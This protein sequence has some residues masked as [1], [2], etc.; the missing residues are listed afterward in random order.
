MA[1]TKSKALVTKLETY[2]R[3]KEKIKSQRKGRGRN[4]NYFLSSLN[5]G[6]MVVRFLTQAEKVERVADTYGKLVRKASYVRASMQKTA[7]VF[8]LSNPGIEFKVEPIFKQFKNGNRRLKGY[9]I[10]RTA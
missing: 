7:K 2:K 4:H 5:P 9:S 1:N 8:S 3:I 6:Q 10:T